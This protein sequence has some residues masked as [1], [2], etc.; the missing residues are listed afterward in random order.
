MKLLYSSSDIRGIG[1]VRS[2][3]DAAGIAYEVRNETMPYPGA[4]FYPEI[5]VV[6]DSALARACELRDAVSKLPTEPQSSWTCPS[7]GEQLEGQFDACWNCGANR[8]AD[9]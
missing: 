4:S 9:S 7:C 8:N 3:L 2:S 5:W 6:E 1:L